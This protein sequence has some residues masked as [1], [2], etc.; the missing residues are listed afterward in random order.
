VTGPLFAAD[1]GEGAATLVL[2]HG[3][4]AN[5]TVWDAL[6][7]SLADDARIL[8]YDL[9]GHGFSLDA[10]GAGRAGATAR[11]ILDDL[12]RRGMERAHVAGHSMGGAIAALMALTAP[13]RVASLTL[14]APGGFGEE[15]DGAL[16][17]RY[18]AAGDEAELAA[19]LGAMSGPDAHV[20]VPGLRPQLEMRA[21]PGQLEKLT[22]IVGMIARDNTQGVIPRESL[23]RLPMP[24]SV[25]WGTL[26]PILPFDQTA[27]LPPGFA[28]RAL[29]RA[30]H[31]LVEEAP[32]AV[33]EAIRASLAG[34]TG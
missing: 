5:H 22:E 4:G 8:A 19:C 31:M 1:R 11:A 29:P 17:G 2:L 33:L 30:G 9:P 21:R 23:D 14:L 12:A 13:E 27:A 7:T 18:A 6:A 25:L 24:A 26:D 34:S 32:D 28:A 20:S 16:L 15:I 10:P 3:F